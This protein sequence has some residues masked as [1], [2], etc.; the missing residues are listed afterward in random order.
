MSQV[1]SLHSKKIPGK[2]AGIGGSPYSVPQRLDHLPQTH[3]SIQ[4]A[5]DKGLKAAQAKFTGGLSPIALAACYSDW[6]LHLSSS[7]GKQL[8]LVE[9]AGKKAWRFANYAASCAVN[10]DKAE[11]C[12]EP[13][14]QDRRFKGDAWRKWPFNVMSQAFLLNQQWWHNATTG[15][16]GVTTQ[17]ENVTTFAARQVLDVFSPSNFA[18]TNPEVLAKTYQD[19]GWNLVRGWQ[20]LVEDISRA[21]SGQGPVGLEAFKVGENLATAPGKVVYRNRLIELIQYAP[22]TETVRPEP[23]FIVPAWIMKYYILD[24]SAQNSLVQYL[25]AQGFTV[26]MV[27][28]KN[29]DAG[30][31]DL[32]MDDY[33]SLGIMDALDAVET[34]TKGSKVHALG[35]CLG[36]TL[37]S[38]AASAM[39]RDG[40]ARLQTLTLLAAQVDFTEAGELTLF[41]ND[42]QLAYLDDMMW[43]KGYLDTTQMAGAFQLLR[44][45]DLIW[46]RVIHD[47]LMGERPE[48][49]DLMA[50]NADATRMPYR[51]HSEYLRS[52]FLNNDLAEGRYRVGG[53]PVAIT[54]IRAPVFLVGTER[55]HVAPW[56]S[57][58]KF[59]LLSDTHVTFVLTSGGHNAGIVSE[60]GHPHRHYRMRPK[61][62]DAQYADPDQWMAQTDPVDGSWWPVL[63]DWLA[64]ASG[65]PVKPPPLGAKSKGYAALCDAPGTYVFQE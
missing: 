22:T 29:P 28:W 33:L 26:F 31:R 45:N 65:D 35:Y 60:P 40:D 11:T 12:V 23:I 8:Q 15:I 47:Y 51:M 43:D 18:L 27:S 5:L 42:S 34:I 36:G 63:A 57:V 16:E 54:D 59:N 20:N 24:L 1:T 46:S 58:Y 52:L 64:D 3:T 14:P 30:D 25:T 2:I 61:A 38:I 44:S 17:H 55:D 10:P 53:R 49:I 32:G 9:K 39:A 50:W 21:N 48:M 19:G 37:L 4:Q 6:A 41:I 13:L 62:K 56:H 7:P